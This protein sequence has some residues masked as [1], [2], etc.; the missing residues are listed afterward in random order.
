MNI[1][2]IIKAGQL[3][4]GQFE[5]IGHFKAAG[6]SKDDTDNPV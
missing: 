1:K 4:K 5:K 6:T 3:K 2:S